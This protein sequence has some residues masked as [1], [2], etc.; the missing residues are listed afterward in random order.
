MKK[1]TFLLLL[2]LFC[3]ISA[4]TKTIDNLKGFTSLEV[5]S[6][7]EV[8]LVKNNENKLEI[9]GEKSTIVEVKNVNGVLKIGLPFST[10]AYENLADGKIKA[11]LFYKENIN[12]ITADNRAIIKG[13]DFKQTNISCIAKERAI[14]ELII[15]ADTIKVNITSGGIVTLS[16]ITK[17]Q[18]INVELYGIYEGFNLKASENTI[19]NAKSGAKAE[20][21]SENKLTPIVGFGGSIFYKGNPQISSDKKINGGIIQK[22]D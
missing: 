22:R 20:V 12:T 19:V 1:L 10:K 11:T 17:K 2:F 14:I 21:Y 15:S 9:E 3:K 8:I 6:G 7:I 16:G 18:N 4:Q 5:T 13:K